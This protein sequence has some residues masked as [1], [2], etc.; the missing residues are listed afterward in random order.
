MD[1]I[2]TSKES[3]FTLI[4][5]QCHSSD[6]RIGIVDRCKHRLLEEEIISEEPLHPNSMLLWY[7]QQER[8]QSVDAQIGLLVEQFVV[9]RDVL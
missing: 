3:N 5:V 6:Y 9:T 8:G 4:L 2:W 1:N 7:D